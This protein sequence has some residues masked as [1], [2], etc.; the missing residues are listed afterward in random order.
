[1]A[2]EY[3]ELKLKGNEYFKEEK[4]QE[5]VEC[6]TEALKL[7]PQ[8]HLLYSNR[9]AAYNKLEKFEEALRPSKIDY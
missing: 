9:S 8:C 4:Y 6:Y 2:Q 1:M 3:E 5:A 7:K